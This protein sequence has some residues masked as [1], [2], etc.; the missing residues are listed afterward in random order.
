MLRVIGRPARAS[1]PLAI[2]A[3]LAPL[4]PAAPCSVEQTWVI[5]DVANIRSGPGYEYDVV[6]TVEWGA[7]VGQLSSSG[8]W[9]E[10]SDSLSGKTGWMLASL[11]GLTS[12]EK[13]AGQFEAY[14]YTYQRERNTYLVWVAPTI[15]EQVVGAFGVMPAIVEAIY[16]VGQVLDPWPREMPDTDWRLFRLM[17]KDDYYYVW[18]VRDDAGNVGSFRI[19]RGRSQPAG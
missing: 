13:G 10:V 5:A 11:A 19:W 14:S 16:G 17:G 8:D 18:V 4:E 12:T 15:P 2:A 6:A 7:S 3:L 9:L 1:L